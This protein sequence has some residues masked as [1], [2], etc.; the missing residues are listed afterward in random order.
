MGNRESPRV[1]LGRL[2]SLSLFLIVLGLFA[3]ASVSGVGPALTR[4]IESEAATVSKRSGFQFEPTTREPQL[5]ILT[6]SDSK[7]GRIRKHPN[8]KAQ[9]KTEEVT[10]PEDED[11]EARR[12]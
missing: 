12:K 4:Q 7:N 8:R 5:Q 11:R 10:K 9:R 6:V 3:T 1:K 2:F